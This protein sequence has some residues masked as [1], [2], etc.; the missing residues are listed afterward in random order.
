[1]KK[2]GHT[3][4]WQEYVAAGTFLHGWWACKMTIWN[5]EIWPGSF[6][7]VKPTPILYEAE[8]LLLGI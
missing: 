6:Y 7:Q 5:L 2:I 8:I 1:M 4:C 3:K